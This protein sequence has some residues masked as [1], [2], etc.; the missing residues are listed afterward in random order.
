MIYSHHQQERSVGTH[1]TTTIMLKTFDGQPIDSNAFSTENLAVSIFAYADGANPCYD[2]GCFIQPQTERDLFAAL[3]SHNVVRHLRRAINRK[4][5][6]K[7]LPFDGKVLNTVSDA[8]TIAPIQYDE[9]AGDNPD[10]VMYRIRETVY[11]INFSHSVAKD[12]TYGG[13]EL[14]L[15]SFRTMFDD[16]PSCSCPA[17]TLGVFAMSITWTNASDFS[18]FWL[19]F[20]RNS[21]AKSLVSQNFNIAKDFPDYD[22]RSFIKNPMM[23]GDG[24]IIDL[25]YGTLPP[26]NRVGF[27]TF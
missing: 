23:Y 11:A 12:M 2:P 10:D 15:D 8:F 24:Y 3:A 21:Y 19:P 17:G 13:L 7:P 9:I 16:F 27:Y 1:P 20:D 6:G 5:H 25:D 14:I 4:C 26:A 22:F 18:S